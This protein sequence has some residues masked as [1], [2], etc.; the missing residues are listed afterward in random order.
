MDAGGEGEGISRLGGWEVTK[1]RTQVEG[2]NKMIQL[3][4]EVLLCKGNLL[5]SEF[6]EKSNRN[7]M[8]LKRI[9]YPLRDFP[10]LPP[11]VSTTNGCFGVASPCFT[12]R[13]QRLTK[14]TSWPGIT[15]LGYGRATSLRI[16]GRVLVT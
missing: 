11:L 10:C 16:A 8:V 5:K 3:H 7:I 2:G 4:N 6:R 15:Q 1:N 9:G 13:S 14:V 12:H